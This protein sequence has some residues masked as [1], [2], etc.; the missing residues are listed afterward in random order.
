MIVRYDRPVSRSAFLA[1]R[2]G[3]FALVMLLVVVLVHRF[4]LVKTPDFVA[5]VLVAAV[6]AALAVPL[7][8]IGL[9]RLWQIGA[10]GGIASVQA[11]VYAALPIAL[12]GYA[13][14]LYDSRPKLTEVSSDLTD[15][16]AWVSVPDANQQ[17]LPRPPLPV[18]ADVMQTEHYPG[19]NGRR[20]EGAIDRV[21][22]AV[23]KVAAANRLVV[24][25]SRGEDY[26][27]P[28]LQLRPAE[29]GQTTTPPSA[30]TGTPPGEE[31]LPE[32]GPLPM[33]RPDAIAALIGAAE[34]AD[35]EPEGEARLQLSTRTFVLG[36]PFD[37]VVRLK[38]EAEMTLVDIRVASRFGPHDLG[39]SDEI[40]E[41][42]LHALD[43]ELLGISG[44]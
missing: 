39:F 7:A 1:R 30:A 22:E 23:R 41:D 18:G 2:L 28:D 34:A 27:L 25:A 21:Y 9:A 40:A 12:P 37:A 15:R 11:L 5:L 38:E 8:L 17:F 36:L 16:P 3:L 14:Y 10:L 19:L 24:T 4:G 32:S 42:F 31:A 35:G 29:D 13:Y 33:R 43:A 44:N 6:P 26:A 20:Y